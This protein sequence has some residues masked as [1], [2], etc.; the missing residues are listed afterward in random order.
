M[1]RLIIDTDPGVDDA[2]ALLLALAHPDVEVEAITTVS[3]NVDLD[4]TTANALK[5]LDAAGKDVPVY[6]GC[7]RPL[8]E[9]PENASHVHG[10]DGLGDCRIPASKKKAQ[11]EHAVHTLVRLANENPGEFTLAAIGPLTNLAVALSM[12]PD[13]PTKFNELVIMGGAIYARGNT[14]TVTAEFNIH[15]DPEAAHRVFSSWPMLTMLSW[16]TT[17][18]QVFTRDVLERF[19]NLGTP[20]AKFFH[21]TN[22]KILGFIREH[23]GQDILFAPDGLALAVAIEPGIVTKSEK[24]HVSIELHGSQTRGQ[25]VVDWYGQTQKPANTEI[26]LELDQARFIQLMEDG[27]R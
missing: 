16:E 1:K 27:L 14:S 6:R 15:T 26:I 24:K 21:D 18:A 22:Q 12:D 13:L 7:D 8:I 10:T 2:H 3:G 11:S 25:T 17:L 19:F 23:L 9:R 4:L 20:R 5:I